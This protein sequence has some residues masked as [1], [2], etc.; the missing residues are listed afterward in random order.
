MTW[1]EQCLIQDADRIYRWVRNRAAGAK[2]GNKK[3]WA[4]LERKAEY[5]S[6]ALMCDCDPEYHKFKRP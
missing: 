2:K 5:V 3:Y 1:E 6:L 4:D